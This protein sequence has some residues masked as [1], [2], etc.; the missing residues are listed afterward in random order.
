M[1]HP[2]AR[3][4]IPNLF[5]A[6]C[7]VVAMMCGAV[8]A[9]PLTDEQKGALRDYF[10]ANDKLASFGSKALELLDKPGLNAFFEQYGDA[11]L[12]VRIGNDLQSAN[13]QEAMK[14]VFEKLGDV[15]IKK[16]AKLDPS[17]AAFSAAFGW[18]S[19]AKTGMELVKKFVYDPGVTSLAVQ[20]YG[21]RREEGNSPEDSAFN[22]P[23]GP[24]R[25]LAQEEFFKTYSKDALLLPGSKDRMRPEWEAKLDQF[26]N[27]WMEDLY[28]QALA[29]KARQ[30]LLAKVA[31]ART[32]VA[33]LELEL[34]KLLGT[35][36]GTGL[37]PE[38]SIALLL[39]ASGSMEEQ[40][41]MDAAKASARRVIGQMTGKVEVA[42]VVFF[43]C[44]DIRVVSPFSTDSAPLLAALEPITPSG[45]TPLA[46]GISFAKEY[47]RTD[48]KGIKRR[49]VVLTD[50]AES[51]SG[52]LIGA[53]KE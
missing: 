48:G 43:E 31:A 28:Q 25:A 40:G 35:D 4:S 49:L 41:R 6:L 21:A 30:V 9:A 7:I 8:V 24:M 13:D 18:F 16:L 51:C 15:A 47:L 45:G 26:L 2:S 17:I 3:P 12:M 38:E 20:M 10:D 39:D 46:A 37:V 23:F 33:G 36:Q 5:A 53:A 34:I 1:M 22:I 50:G 14:K 44:G 32:E 52:D 29:E 42:L 19:F 27:A 11:L